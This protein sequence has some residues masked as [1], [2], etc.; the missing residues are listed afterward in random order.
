LP[1]CLTDK[2]SSCTSLGFDG[3]C[4]TPS[5]ANKCVDP[6]RNVESIGECYTIPSNLQPA[7]TSYCNAG[8]HCCSDNKCHECCS[9]GD[10]SGYDSSTH[11]KLVCECP[12]GCSLS[13]NSYSCKP[14]SSCKKN[15]DCDPNY[16]CDYV[17]GGNG[18]CVD[19]GNITNYGGKSYLC[20]PPGWGISSENLTSKTEKTQKN[21]NS[22]SN[23]NL[24]NLPFY[25]LLKIFS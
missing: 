22:N 17:I 5:G 11:T 23:V 24:F 20:D 8:L 12:S 15:S 16:C 4:P 6:P 13:G 3:S 25:F 2:Y 19:K 14:L 9:D 7:G 18:K 21:E 1:V 10:C